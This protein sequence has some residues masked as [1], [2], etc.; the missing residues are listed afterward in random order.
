MTDS[1]SERSS[2]A[3]IGGFLRA[4]RRRLMAERFIDSLCS[5]VF[6]ALC[7]VAL[8]AL[9]DRLLLRGAFRWEAVVAV[10]T[11]AVGA[12]LLRTL[13]GGDLT[14]FHAAVQADERLGLRER[15]SSAFYAGDATAFDGSPESHAATESGRTATE[16]NND[17]RDLVV[18]DAGK[19]L[20]DVKL[21][22]V[23][24]IH[25]PRR[26]AWLVLPAL[27]SVGLFL[28]VPSFDPLGLV[29]DEPDPVS[30]KKAIDKK[31][32]EIEQKLAELRE[33]AEKNNSEET[34]KLLTLLSKQVDQKK[35]KFSPSS[36]QKP[37]DE[38][39]SRDLQKQAL[40]DLT[41][42]QKILKNGI[43]QDKFKSLK[44][45]MKDLQGLSVKAARQ[46]RALQAALKAGDLEK[47]KRELAALQE[48]LRDLSKKTPSDLTNGDKALMKQLQEE[49]ARLSKDAGA[50]TQI[51]PGLGAM[52]R[53]SAGDM[54]QILANMNKFNNDLDSLAK[55]EADLDSLNQ[56][57]DLL[58]RSKQEFAKLHSCLDCGKKLSKPGGT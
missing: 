43:E 23:F 32:S 55:L 40:L 19:S 12:A 3:A 11:L 2:R 35:E 37:G 58:K 18:R 9:A 53:L 57:M 22:A 20:R 24:P 47:A 17:W 30:L 26:A 28:W 45:A 6:V 1:K 7:L 33:Q 42:R 25:F 38:R 49:L 39:S 54:K 31:K 13:F 36:L 29:A 14:L 34:K 50:L 46:T 52:G 8:L 51:A 10:L 16:R 15:V 48:K 56:A 5:S 41:K 21:S 4:A 44:K 27:V